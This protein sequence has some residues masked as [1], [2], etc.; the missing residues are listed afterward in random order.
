M[1]GED[2]NRVPH[3]I[4]RGFCEKRVGILTSSMQRL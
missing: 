2:N 3:S 1:C 4:F